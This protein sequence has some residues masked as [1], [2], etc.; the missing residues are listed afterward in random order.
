M[1]RRHAAIGIDTRPYQICQRCLMDT[2]DPLIYFDGDG[3]CNHCT[4][5][6]TNRL[7]VI[8]DAQVSSGSLESLFGRIR[9][10][11]RGRKYDCVVGV[12]GGVDSSYVASL[13]TEHGLRI[14]AVHLDNG[15]N[16]KVAVENI[17]V[18]ANSLNMGYASYVLPW[19]EFRRVQLAFLQAS[20]PEAE[21]P[22][23]VAIQRALHHHA[24]RNGIKY[25]LSGGNIASEGI[26]PVSWHYNARDTK[27]SHSILDSAGCPRSYFGSQRFGALD[28]AYH[29]V[30]R[31]IRTVYPLNYVSYDRSLA[32]QHLE[33]RYGW[34]Y[35]GAK[36]GE[37]RFTRFV[38]GY[39]LYIK[40]GIDY[41]RA[42]MSSEIILKV[43]DRDEALEVLK[44]PPYDPSSISAELD[45][46]AKKLSISRE[47]LD[48]IVAEEP[49][50]Y[51]DYATNENKLA[52]LYKVYR[53]F[54]GRAKTS[55][56]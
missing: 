29:K 18:L 21:T 34:K 14:L 53:Y 17:R 44:S 41:R 35:Y 52:I 36:H 6:I 7:E 15:W 19:T 55:N 9:S 33:D 12:S 54:T 3:C 4:D 32:Q 22:T 40:H 28:E 50:W 25:I 2:S 47:Q 37:S 11:G 51:F 45:Y 10:S 56:F 43:L 1:E 46:I 16:S 23:D 42:T 38:Q 48:H 8:N 31:G 27:Y 49:K 26:L 5:F 24:S 20:V 30:I 13:A 39:Y